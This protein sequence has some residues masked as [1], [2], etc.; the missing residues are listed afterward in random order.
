MLPRIGILINTS[1]REGDRDKE[2][3]SLTFNF[4]VEEAGPS[5]AEEPELRDLQQEEKDGDTAVSVGIPPQKKI[6]KTQPKEE[7]K[8]RKVSETGY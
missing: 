8:R 5:D 6:H 1:S 3:Q 7:L 4:N 2:P